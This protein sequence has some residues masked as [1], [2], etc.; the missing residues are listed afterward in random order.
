MSGIAVLIGTR[1][2][3]IKLMPVV[4]ALEAAGAAPSVWITGQHREMLR[5]I[6]AE[7]E[8]RV[9]EDLRLM[10]PGQ[11]LADLIIHAG[12]FRDRF[13]TEMRRHYLEMNGAGLFN[14]TIKR[15]PP[16]I[17]DTL[18]LAG[19]AVG[20]VDYFVL[21]QS[22]RFMMLHLA[23][24]FE[25]AAERVPL[26]LGEFGNTGG[27]SVPLTLTNTLPAARDRKLSV[28][29]IGYGVGLSWG[30]ALADIAP[31]VPLAHIDI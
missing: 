29:M 22:N 23:K 12:G 11:G 9:D 21:H 18:K 3:A 13:S 24:K 28:M 15:V 31:D 2:E 5:P 30:A 4:R 10:R 6:L 17:E 16:L 14:F 1:P 20:D 7:L 27:P 8:L 26:T 19:R 25:L